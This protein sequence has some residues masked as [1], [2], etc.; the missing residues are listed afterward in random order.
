[1][2][3]NKYSFVFITFARTVAVLIVALIVIVEFPLPLWS[4]FQL[5]FCSS[6][7]RL[8]YF[9]LRHKNFFHFFFNNKN[10]QLFQK[11]FSYTYDWFTTA[12]K[13]NPCGFRRLNWVEPASLVLNPQRQRAFAFAFSFPS[14]PLSSSFLLPLYE[15]RADQEVALDQWKH[16]N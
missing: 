14:S 15:S 4:R 5:F 16:V 13:T 8:L 1:M 9:S 11:I 10:T 6:G 7:T 2:L 12:K 3:R